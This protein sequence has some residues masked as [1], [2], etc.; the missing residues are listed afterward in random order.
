MKLVHAYDGTRK[1]IEID[2]SHEIMNTQSRK[3]LSLIPNQGK[4][5]WSSRCQ[6][7]ESAT[8][9]AFIA[10][11]STPPETKPLCHLLSINLRLS[12]MNF[13]KT[14]SSCLYFSLSLRAPEDTRK[15]AL[16]MFWCSSVRD[17][18][19]RLNPWASRL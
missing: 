7:P 16:Q 4:M 19:L 2:P 13:P 10:T 15:L 14:H 1:V 6:Y 9:R 18:T 3:G 11:L 12:S 17:D 5:T 8:E